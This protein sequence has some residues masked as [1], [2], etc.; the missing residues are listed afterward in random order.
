MF[1]IN[2]AYILHVAPSFS[3]GIASFCKNLI[4]YQ[5]NNGYD[6][7]IITFKSDDKDVNTFINNFI[8]SIDIFL[9]E[10][11]VLN[12]RAMLTGVNVRH[13]IKIIQKRNPNKKILIHMHNTSSIG[14]IQDIKK[15]RLVCTIHGINTVETKPSDF[16]N[17]YIIK[18][19][20]RYN[21]KIIGVSEHTTNYYNKRLNTDYIK[22]IYNGT[23]TCNN[24]KNKQKDVFIIGYVSRIVSGKGLD[25]LLHA[26]KIL[27]EKYKGRIKLIIAGDGPPD[28]INR[29]KELIMKLDINDSVNYLG[30]VSDAG[31]N[32]IPKLDL[33][34]LPSQSEG[35]PMCIAE[36]MG[37][38]I[39]VLATPVGGIP[40]IVKDGY[41]GLIIK[42]EGK[43]I[44]S[45]IEILF[46]DADKYNM[47][48]S[49]ARETYKRFLTVDRMGQ[50]YDQVYLEILK[51]NV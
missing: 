10:N 33:L 24:E 39:P 40:E 19:L 30:F 26:I 8:N 36:A 22:T 15:Y 13:V 49:N 5:I 16:A 7:G 35:L 43:D 38:D 17:I 48:S 20:I 6:V 23:N 46:K 9:I 18:K 50:Q 41:N 42:R 34:V 21:K 47:M 44:A 37:H 2:R 51:E 1:K 12:R 27:K 45:K 3:G 25:K 29:M 4:S 28:Q 14:M 11:N 32:V 31:N